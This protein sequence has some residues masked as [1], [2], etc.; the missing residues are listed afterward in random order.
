MSKKFVIVAGY[1][2]SGS[3]ALIDLLMEFDKTYVP[4][5]EFC[6]AYFPGGLADLRYALVENW[7]PIRSNAAIG[8]FLWL[9]KK[10]NMPQNHRLS[11]AGLNYANLLGADFMDKTL[12][13]IHSLVDFTYKGINYH[14]NFKKSYMQFTVGKVFRSMQ[15][16]THGR[17][18]IDLANKDLYFAHPSEDAF[19]EASKRYIDSLFDK[20]EDAIIV[21]DQAVSPLDAAALSRF[22]N[23]AKM[24]I[25]DR[26]PRD[27]YIDM[28]NSEGLIGAELKLS[29]DVEKYLQWHR[30]VR[31]QHIPENAMSIRFEEIV[32][33]TEDVVKQIRRFLDWDIGEWTK[34]GMRFMPEESVNNIGLWMKDAY[35]SMRAETDRIY[36]ELIAGGDVE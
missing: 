7:D 25:V 3:S 17:I 33:D 27:I 20:N 6:L 12:D 24:I 32:N 19:C 28:I 14:E 35:K 8:D 4:N 26:D 1:G 22:F 34:R 2:W 23:D 13:F 5:V 36:N 11:P 18:D 15:R 31:P 10:C 21:L 30:A 16:R 29:H 9:C